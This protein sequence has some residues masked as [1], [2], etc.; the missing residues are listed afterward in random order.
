MLINC[1]PFEP[2]QIAG[3]DY[4]YC[5]QKNILDFRN[6]TLKIEAWNESFANRII[7][8]EYCTYFVSF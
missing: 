3:V 1:S 8:Q 5:L 7:I 4:F 6:R 2:P